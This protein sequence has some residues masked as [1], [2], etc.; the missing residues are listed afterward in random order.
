MS[1]EKK[2][3]KEITMFRKMWNAVSEDERIKTVFI[4]AMVVAFFFIGLSYK[5]GRAWKRVPTVLMNETQSSVIGYGDRL[6]VIAF[7][8][9][10]TEGKKPQ[11]LSSDVESL[12]Y[13][14]I[15]AEV[16]DYCFPEEANEGEFHLNVRIWV[17][18]AEDQA[19]NFCVPAGSY[20]VSSSLTDSYWDGT[21]VNGFIRSWVQHQVAPY[22][23]EP[24]PADTPT[25]TSESE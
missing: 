19:Q 13:A 3:K 5:A 9:T 10:Q 15:K 22:L 16:T 7:T 25:A 23:G 6:Y 18:D 2:D 11:I 8:E 20:L 1:E 24:S 14:T 12:V 21:N 17:E 4:I